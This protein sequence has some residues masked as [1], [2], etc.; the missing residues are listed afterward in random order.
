MFE[1]C[2][3]IYL[4]PTAYIQ[5]R[6]TFGAYLSLVTLLPSLA[7]LSSHFPFSF[8]FASCF[9]VFLG[10]FFGGKVSQVRPFI[11]CLFVCLLVCLCAEIV[12]LLACTSIVTLGR[13][14]EWVW[15]FLA[16]RR[17]CPA[18]LLCCALS[19]EGE[20]ESGSK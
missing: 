4:A 20:W 3:C 1:E 5:P 12:Y 10:L 15:L 7:V 17:F 19:E 16:T 13:D 8:S 6:R 11:F 2:G 9:L 18:S 14:C